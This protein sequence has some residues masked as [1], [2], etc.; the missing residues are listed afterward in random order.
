MKEIAHGRAVLSSESGFQG[1]PRMR[2]KAS[3]VF[4]L[5]ALLMILALNGFSRRETPILG[6][7]FDIVIKNGRVMDPGTSRS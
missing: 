5:A 1:G 4:T 6:E 2:K 3:W 7:E